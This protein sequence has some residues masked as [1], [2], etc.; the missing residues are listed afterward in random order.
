MAIGYLY[1]DVV[2]SFIPVDSILGK[3]Y[4]AP[5]VGAALKAGP[6]EVSLNIALVGLTLPV[7]FYDVATHGG[8]RGIGFVGAVEPEVLDFGLVY[9]YSRRID[10]AP[11]LVYRSQEFCVYHAVN[12]ATVITRPETLRE[13]A[14]L[15]LA[16]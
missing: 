8:Q 14:E 5:L 7:K 9:R 13:I 1:V 10:K 12:S 4:V 3:I 15:M 11:S 2:R 16:I 6:F